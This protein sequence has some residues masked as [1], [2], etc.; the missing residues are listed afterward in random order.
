M[1]PSIYD[2]LVRQ[3]LESS[4]IPD[5][6]R[7]FVSYQHSADQAYYDVFS[8]HYHDT[9][10]S[11]FDNSLERGGITSENPDYVIQ[12]IRDKYITGTSCTIV[13]CGKTSHERKYLD[14]EIKGTLDKEHGLIGIQ[15]PTLI[16]GIN[17]MVTVPQRLS[18]N[19]S[20]GYAVW[21]GWNELAQNPRLLSTWIQEATNRSK[22]LIQ[23]AGTI[24]QRNG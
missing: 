19:I 9:Y 3:I 11:I 16:A 23:N 22:K 24:K 10:E 20:S 12:Q 13:L 2:S 5:R 15:L 8:R 4:K 6:P 17:G 21:K 18:A 7:I 14:W 1:T